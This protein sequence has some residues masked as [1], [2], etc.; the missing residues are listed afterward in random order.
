MRE[1]IANLP[2]EARFLNFTPSL[3]WLLAGLRTYRRGHSSEWR[4][5][6]PIFPVFW[7]TSGVWAFVPAYRCGAVPVS[8][9]I[10]FNVPLRNVTSNRTT[11]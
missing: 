1:I 11:T 5:Y 9:R 3:A 8:H 10:P 6:L 2:A 4:F 7:I